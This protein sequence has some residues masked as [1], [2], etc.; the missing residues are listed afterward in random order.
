MSIPVV[1]KLEGIPSPAATAWIALLA[2][3]TATF[4][5]CGDLRDVSTSSRSIPDARRA[6]AI[7]NDPRVTHAS[8]DGFNAMSASSYQLGE[9]DDAS[10]QASNPSTSS[11][12][13]ETRPEVDD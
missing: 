5:G 1:T 4:A 6:P 9:V 2:S 10:N 13:F 11:I 7:S 3:V 8:A 12:G